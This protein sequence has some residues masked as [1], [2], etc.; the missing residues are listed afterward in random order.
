MGEVKK[1]L[2]LNIQRDRK[3]HALAI[4]QAS[5]I[6]ETLEK[7][8]LTNAKPA[9]LPVSDRGTLVATLP[10]EPQAAQSL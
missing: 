2:G 6:E 5:Y 8:N 4:S 10:N 9:S 3:R 1:I 7:F